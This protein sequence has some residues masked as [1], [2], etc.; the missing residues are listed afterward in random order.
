MLS[1]GSYLLLLRSR[2]G[3]GEMVNHLL[4]VFGIRANNIRRI[5]VRKKPNT[6]P[7]HES[8]DRYILTSPRNTHITN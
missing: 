6:G 7:Y 5:T 4:Y 3:V 8:G 1:H 2:G